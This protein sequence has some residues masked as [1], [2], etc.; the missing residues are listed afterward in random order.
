MTVVV[1]A[2]SQQ[3]M[4]TP[5]EF[6]LRMRHALHLI[7]TAKPGITS[8]E[9]YIIRIYRR[10]VNRPKQIIGVS[11]HVETGEKNRFENFQQLSGIILNSESSIR[12]PKRDR[13][14]KENAEPTKNK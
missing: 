4:I 2:L 11:E 12:Q 5:G 9:T 8:M 13:A 10:L 6:Y 14:K 7:F 3:C 1:D